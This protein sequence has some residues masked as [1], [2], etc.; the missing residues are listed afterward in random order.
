MANQTK[1]CLKRSGAVR[2]GKGNYPDQFFRKVDDRQGIS[3]QRELNDCLGICNQPLEKGHVSYCQP[4][5]SHVFNSCNELFVTSFKFAYDTVK[6]ASLRIP[7]ILLGLLLALCL[8]FGGTPEPCYSSPIPSPVRLPGHVPTKAL[9]SAKLLGGLAPDT[10]IPMAIVLPLRNQV[11]LQELLERIYDPVDQL[12][13]HY[14]TPKEFTDR[15]GPTQADYDAVTVYARNLGFTVTRTHSNRTILDVSGP[16]GTVE[17]AFTIHFQRYQTPNGREFYAPDNDPEVPGSIASLIVGV[18]GLDNAAVWHPHNRSISAAEMA[19]STPFQIGTGPGNALAPSDILTA[20]NLQGVAANGSGQTL[21]LFEL[22]GFNASDVA[23]YVSYYGL[24]SVPVM[25]VLIDSATGSAGSNADEVTLDIELQIALAPGAS[26]IVVYEGPNSGTGIVDTY[27]AIANDN[28]NLPMQ[29]STSWGLSEGQIGTTIMNSENTAFQQMAAQGQSIY[30]SSG[31][32]GA[33]DNGSTL[34]VDDPASQPYMVG[35]GGTTLSVNSNETY[36]SETTWSDSGGGV[37]SIWPIPSW[38]QGIASEASTSKR[39]VPDVSFNADPNTGYSIYYKGAWTVYGGTSCVAPLWAAFTARVNQQRVAGGHP[40]LGFA[41]PAIYQLA[42]GSGYGSDFHDVTTG[43]NGYYSAGTGYDNATGWGSFNGANLL[44]ALASISVSPHTPTPPTNVTASAGNGQA[45]VIFSAP[46]SDGGSAITSYTVTGTPTSGS[47]KTATD[48]AS[49][50]TLTGLANG[51]T[52]T[53]T[54]TATNGVGNSLPSL[55][56]NSVKPS[57]HASLP[58][59]P[60]GVTASAGNGQ[61][62][63][64]FTAPTSNGGSTILYYTATSSPGN[65]TATSSN[66]PITLT[67]LSNGTAYTFTVTATNG[68][69]TGPASAAS[70]PVTPSAPPSAVPAATPLTLA[71]TGMALFV[72]LL[73]RK[74]R[75]TGKSGEHHPLK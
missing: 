25:T 23:G 41:N 63:V 3:G 4:K 2:K 65:I 30:A 8:A 5:E 68:E 74:N 7:K 75:N 33:D 18:V 6:I 20:Y 17:A 10:Q 54:V 69:G 55:P 49:P 47:T 71:G 26:K 61:A 45:I 73:R 35:T 34:S 27:N 60:T 51:T 12:Y 44:V 48:T 36:L 46:A 28:V 32:H 31:D 40:T 29:I 13:G 43:S 59:A 53:F 21:G 66:S 57:R 14:L 52:Y 64:S 62:T 1:T 56:S 38:Q 16:A 15:F 67:G 22:D 42:T 11:K 9:A 50:I 24:P 37:S 70:S 58:G 19:Q 39:N 72:M